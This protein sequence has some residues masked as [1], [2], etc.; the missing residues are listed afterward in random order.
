MPAVI[1]FHDEPIFDRGDIR[2]EWTD[3]HL[4]SKFDSIQLAISQQVPNDALGIGRVAPKRT[5]DIALLAFAHLLPSPGRC[6]ASLS[7]KRER[8]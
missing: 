4:P 2:N 3:G 1:Q 6:A 7:R 8:D 5:S